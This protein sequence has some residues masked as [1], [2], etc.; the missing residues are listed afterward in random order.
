M[1]LNAEFAGQALL[2]DDNKTTT[3][4]VGDAK[5]NDM[6]GKDTF[7]TGEFNSVD[8]Y[9][10]P[11]VIGYAFIIWTRLPKWLETEF[12]AFKKI[13]QNNFAGFD[14]LSD[15]ELTTNT[16]TEGFSVNEYNVAAS[17]GAKPSSFNLKHLEYSGSIIRNMYM[18][19]SSMIRDP[20]TNIAVYPKIAS[21]ESEKEYR[22]FNHTG[23]LMYIVTRPDANNYE[24]EKGNIE[25]A[26]YWTAVMPKKIPIGHFNYTKGS[27]ETPIEIDMP[28]S[29]MMHFGKN[30]NAKA[31]ELLKDEGARLYSFDT[32]ND[33]NTDSWNNV[34]SS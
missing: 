1:P 31:K 3:Q 25:F 27:Q 24:T 29:G 14:G 12:P 4:F 16:V 22:A 18:F 8:L 20:R 13:T 2:N 34:G 19:W 6:A 10:D 33:F 21:E 15:I 7:F 23:E 28:F 32:E 26:A 30:V 9:Y 17:I 5:H 11:L